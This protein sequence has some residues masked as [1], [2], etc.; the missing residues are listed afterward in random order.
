MK[1]LESDERK[2]VVI[3]AMTQVNTQNDAG[4][5][6]RQ[7]SFPTCA[8][9]MKLEK[10][11]EC[12]QKNNLSTNNVHI[13]K[14]MHLFV[15]VCARVCKCVNFSVTL[16]ALISHV[17]TR[18][19]S[20]QGKPLNIMVKAC[21]IVIVMLLIIHVVIGLNVQKI[22]VSKHSVL[23]SDSNILCVCKREHS[24]IQLCFNIVAASLWYT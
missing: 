20:P 6:K 10:P 5:I 7:E 13:T 3:K 19:F 16:Q 17:G 2:L 21:F 15:C 8:F 4:E 24:I 12:Y 1:R 14:K 18:S 11:L 9:Q 23:P 22:K